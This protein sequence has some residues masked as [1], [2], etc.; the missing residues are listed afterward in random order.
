VTL[1]A[2]VASGGCGYVGGGHGRVGSYHGRT[3]RRAEV[4]GQPVVTAVIAAAES[5]VHFDVCE[6][7]EHSAAFSA[8]EHLRAMAA[9]PSVARALQF[10]LLKKTNSF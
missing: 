8:G 2:A 4:L 7:D 9:M 10:I 5:H 6:R 1:D 3:I